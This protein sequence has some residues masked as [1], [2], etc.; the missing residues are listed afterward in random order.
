MVGG[1]VR[2][3]LLGRAI[4]DVDLVTTD[5]P[6]TVARVV[7]SAAGG[8]AF[9]LSEEFGAWRVISD[10]G[11]VCDVSPLQGGTIE[12]DLGKRDFSVNA[13]AMTLT[14]PAHVVDP[15]SGRADLDA[16]VLRVLGEHSYRDDALRPLRLVRLATELSL[17]PDPETE[18]LTQAY[19]G[20]VPET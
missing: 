13:M 18:R 12:E 10:A 17:V 3:L 14:L 6:A 4:T 16:G 11:F 5:D 15:H 20:R 19:A 8:P 1:V 7:A 2:D 9:P